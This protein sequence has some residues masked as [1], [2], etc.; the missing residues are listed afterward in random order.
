MNTGKER[1]GA[2]T[3]EQ[4]ARERARSLE[5]KGIEERFYEILQV[6]A[7]KKRLPTNGDRVLRMRKAK[8][9]KL[10]EPHTLETYSEFN[11]AAWRIHI[12][13]V[14]V[15]GALF[16]ASVTAVFL[17]LSLMAS[18]AIFGVLFLIADVYPLMTQRYNY[19]RMKRLGLWREDTSR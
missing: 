9:I 17:G 19:L 7:Y 13:S 11:R 18:A 14:F 1:P 6:R 3:H 16:A 12:Q 15:T 8:A 10:N 5:R 2:V 4:V